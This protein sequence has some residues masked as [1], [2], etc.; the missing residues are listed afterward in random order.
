M[1]F[2]DSSSVTF[3]LKRRQEILKDTFFI[4][5]G[6]FIEVDAQCR[7]KTSFPLSLQTRAAL[8]SSLCSLL[9]GKSA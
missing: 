2:Q 4:T 3:S 9:K 8:L 5:G 7:T 1:T 6:G